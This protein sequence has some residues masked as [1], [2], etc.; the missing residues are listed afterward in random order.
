MIITG[1]RLILFSW[2][3]CLFYNLWVFVC[4]FCVKLCINSMRLLLS[5]EILSIVG[6][7]IAGLLLYFLGP[8][9]HYLIDFVAILRVSP[10]YDF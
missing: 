6:D 10:V 7:N 3:N 4:L 1:I 8:L 5:E 9:K 2:M